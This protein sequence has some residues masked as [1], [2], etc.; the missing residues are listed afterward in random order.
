MVIRV[1]PCTSTFPDPNMCASSQTGC[2]GGSARPCGLVPMRRSPFV[3]WHEA[4]HDSSSAEDMQ[5]AS[6]RK[7]AASYKTSVRLQWYVEEM[8]SAFGRT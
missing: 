8:A 1:T 3:A 2:G 4:K 5:T 7:S 6:G